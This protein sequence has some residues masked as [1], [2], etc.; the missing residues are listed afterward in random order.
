[1]RKKL[2]F[3][4]CFLCESC[5]NSLAKNSYLPILSSAYY[6][7]TL[8]SMRKTLLSLALTTLTL[9]SIA[10]TH[11]STGKVDD[12]CVPS[13]SAPTEQCLA[14]AHLQEVREVN[15][16]RQEENKKLRAT[17]TGALREFHDTNSGAIR[18]T[19]K[20]LTGADRDAWKDARD[21][22]KELVQSLSGKTVEERL[23]S[24]SGVED[25]TRVAIEARYK[26]NPELLA[27]R[28]AVYDANKARRDQITTNRLTSLLERSSARADQ[29]SVF[30]KSVEAK[31]A[32]LTTE[33]KA[34]I[35]MKIDEQIVKINASKVLTAESKASMVAEL[36]ALKAKLQ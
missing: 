24:R 1:M 26:N 12:R 11:A 20:S 32:T 5:V 34:N 9:A 35:S 4:M 13:D 2:S 15:K 18:E 16:V 14:R 6:F 10:T 33:Q 28:L 17:N 30:V 3:S 21:D 36:T 23:N 29:V 19:T 27:A 31:L 7:L 22:R 8:F 25:A